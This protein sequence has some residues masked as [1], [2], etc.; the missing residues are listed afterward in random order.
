MTK[1]ILKIYD[2]LQAHRPVAAISAVLLVVAMALSMLTISYKEDISDFLPLES[3][4]QDELKIFQNISGASRVFAIVSS[5]DTIESA[6]DTIAAA[7]YAFAEELQKRDTAHVVRDLTAAIDMDRISETADFA[8]SNI[9]YFITEQDFR[10]I[11]SLL[12]NPPFVDEQLQRDKQML[13]FPAGGLLSDNLQRDP[14]NI[15]T[16]IVSRLQSTASGLN[17][18]IYNGCIFSPDM[19]KA[20]VMLTSPY[21]ASETENNSSLLNLL[22]Q[23]ADST[24]AHFASVSI[25]FTGG[26]A[27]AVGNASQIKKDSTLSVAISVLLILLLLGTSLR[28]T[29]NILLI[30]LSIAFGWLFAMGGLALVHNNV[31]IIVI[32]ISSVII[33]IAVNYPLHLV[34]HLR[35]TPNVRATL[36]EIATPLI[37]GNITTVGAFLALVPLKSIAL[38]DLGIFS[39]LLLAGTILFVL[40]YLPHLVKVRPQATE[41][42]STENPIRRKGLVSLLANISFG[43]KSITLTLIG[44]LT[45]VFAFFSLRTTF[46]SN[47]ANIN[48]MPDEQ[49]ADMEYFQKMLPQAKDTKRIYVASQD[50]SLNRALEKSLSAQRSI[51]GMLSSGNIKA[52][53]NC[54]G[55][56][57]P[58]SEQKRRLALWEKLKKKHADTLHD[59]LIARSA[60]NGFS[61]GSFNEFYDILNASYEPQQ[62]EYFMPIAKAILSSNLSIDSLNHEYAVVDLVDVVPARADS[63]KKALTAACKQQHTFDVES[64]NSTIADNLS[65][66]FNYI[67]WVCGCIVFFFLWLSL[68]S[69]EL[70]IISFIPMAV[71]WVWILG[72]MAMLGI[73]FNIVNIILATFIFGQ[74][75]DYTIFMTEGAIYEYT[76]RRKMLASYKHSIILSALIMFIGIGSLIIAKHPAL[77]SL[78]EVTV[79]GMFSVVLMAC[80]FPVFIFKWL[81]MKNGKDRLRPLSLRPMLLMVVC[82]T[83][84]F[85]H[86]AFIYATGFFLF[87]LLKPN[88]K[89]K[90]FFHRLVHK[91]YKWDLSHIP[92]IALRISG[93]RQIPGK[94]HMIVAN[95]QSMLDSALMMAISPKLIIIANNNASSNKLISRVFKWLDFYTIPDNGEID[96]DVL[97]QCV[98]DGYSIMMFPE[99]QRNPESSILRFHKGAF[100]IACELGLN[101][102]PVIIHGA[103]DVLPRNSLL[104]FQGRITIAID[105]VIP[106]PDN[107]CDYSELTKNV[108]CQFRIRYSTIASTIENTSYYR[109]F[110]LDLY[111]YRG[112]E[113][114][115]AVRKNINR[116]L[117]FTDTIDK[118]ILQKTIKVSDCGYGESAILM[119]LVHKE[120]Q[121]EASIDDTEK[122]AVARICAENIPNLTFAEKGL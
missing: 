62:P 74:G 52:H 94:P 6:R 113:I 67:G 51:Q 38:R 56:M 101:I 34:T 42:E 44:I 110:V 90:A 105:P 83:V 21:G 32:G 122:L 98:N 45:A 106:I 4:H 100:K 31:S 73:N 22:R 89:T 117:C 79:I 41:A 27:I 114:Y 5:S 92:G 69:L 36:S 9:P 88:K 24:S 3:S 103:N 17:Y 71:S 13:M 19:R 78:A 102:Q 72:I 93:S 37:V 7:V 70:A 29:R 81:V 95:H 11:D 30:A 108:N 118:P 8:Y 35:H 91:L 50:T 18:E 16:P 85:I 20:I 86:L 66:N 14:L 115:T 80:L 15:F 116:N 28:N 43:N 47:I 54:I 68:G 23:S 84:Y 59:F 65:N 64:M 53:R 96:M 76:Y 112:A 33:G 75:D 2:Y 77:H 111:R 57:P 104:A 25:S 63:V 109:K 87:S 10:H 49:R 39:S 12:S 40:L 46:D 1:L 82:A 99:G 26:P 60:A 61:A 97:R 48:Y 55:F 58:I 121:V 107:E 119:A 120:A